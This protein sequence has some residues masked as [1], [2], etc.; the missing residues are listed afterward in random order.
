MAGMGSV[1]VSLPK[2]AVEYLDR[3]AEENYT[4]RAG[5]ARQYL[6][7]KLEEKAVVEARTKG[8]SIR[9]ASEMT[10]VPYARV[11]KILGQTQIDEE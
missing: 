6:M 9:K 10:G 5:I 7:E 8:Y 3:Q 2:K 1:N 11:L 4:S